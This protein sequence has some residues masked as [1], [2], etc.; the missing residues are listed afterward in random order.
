ME[1]IIKVSQFI[2]ILVI[3]A[4]VIHLGL[5][6]LVA[7]NLDSD[8]SML[9]ME[10][11]SFPFKFSYSIDSSEAK[12]LAAVDMNAMI[13]LELPTQF[14]YLA[15]YL[16][17]YRLF[18]EYKQARIFSVSA[19]SQLRN[20]GVILIGLPL[21]GA[22]YPPLLIVSL[23]LMSV[24]EHGEINLGFAA[25]DLGLVVLG[26]MLTVVGWIMGEAQK[27]NEEQELT[28]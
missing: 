21:F 12:Q 19:T 20:L 5:G 11:E 18:S 28:I 9:T 27:I 17:I 3:L 2:R 23:K 22:L 6:L 14:I 4:A 7:A 24:L 13:W 25:Y 10:T 16:F 8:P 1:K 26:I 15:I